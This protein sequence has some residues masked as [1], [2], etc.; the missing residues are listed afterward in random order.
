MAVD[1][2]LGEVVD[3]AVVVIGIFGVLGGLV[4][5]MRDVMGGEVDGGVVD[6]SGGGLSGADAVGG[7]VEC[8]D[9]SEPVLPIVEGGGIDV[10]GD[11]VVVGGDVGEFE[12]VDVI[13]VQVSGG[14]GRVPGAVR[15]GV[16]GVAL[17][18]VRVSDGAPS[19][20]PASSVYGLRRVWWC[21]PSEV[22]GEW[23]GE[24]DGTAEHGTGG[25]NAD[26]CAVCSEQDVLWPRRVVTA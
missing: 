20:E 18:G 26:G 25:G 12:S 6:V 17:S 11:V 14:G 3:A 2:G 22:C 8:V 4:E 15:V 19:G 24:G 9:G 7:C 16:G 1:V 23:C 5:E 21:G 13:G 10:D